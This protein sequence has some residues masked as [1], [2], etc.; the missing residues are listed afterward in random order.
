MKEVTIGSGYNDIKFGMSREQVKTIL[1]EPDETDCFTSSDEEG[2]NTEA[3]HYDELELSVSFDELDEWKLTSIAVSA[4]DVTV[5]GD[6]LMGLSADNLLM[7]VEEKEL[8]EFERE[9]ISSP[10][11]PDHEVVSFPESSINFWL[12]GGVVTEIQ[13][14]PFWDEEE[15]AYIW[16]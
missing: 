14:G 4:E 12:E 10:E 9:D 1:G 16:E 2:D 5:E 3:Y 13:F 11:V 6:K 8:G 7:K 15:E